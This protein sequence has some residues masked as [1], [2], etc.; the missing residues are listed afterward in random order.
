MQEPQ[1]LVLGP[2]RLDRLY[3]KRSSLWLDIKLI[4]LSFWISGRGDWLEVKAIDNDLS[5]FIRKE[6]VTPFDVVGK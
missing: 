2:F 1:C 4:L 6:F 3:L 5:G